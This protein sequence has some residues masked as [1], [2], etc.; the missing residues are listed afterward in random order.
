MPSAIAS[1][2][3]SKCFLAISIY[4][5]ESIFILFS[6]SQLPPPTPPS[7]PPRHLPLPSYYSYVIFNAV[8]WPRTVLPHYEPDFYANCSGCCHNKSSFYEIDLAL[9]AY[10][11]IYL[12]WFYLCSILSWTAYWL[13]CTWI[14]VL[15]WAAN[16]WLCARNKLIFI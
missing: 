11:F 4:T 12:I 16:A 14:R 1:L 9:A 13:K 2:R 8:T 7:S 3:P 10:L 15:K 5:D 6:T